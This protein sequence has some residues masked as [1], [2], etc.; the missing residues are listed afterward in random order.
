M[1]YTI[2]AQMS[3]NASIDYHI[4]GLYKDKKLNHLDK[5]LSSSIKATIKK[6]IENNE[7]SGDI[8]DY[9]IYDNIDQNLKVIVFGLGNK[10]KLSPIILNKIIISVLK[11]ISKTNAKNIS[12]NIKNI[13][14]KN[15][16]DTAI[17]EVIIASESSEYKFSIKKV[18]SK[19]SLKKC[20]LIANSKVTKNNFNQ[21][22]T[23]SKAISNGI[24]KA[25]DL[26]N[27]PP[28]ICTPTYLSNEA[29]KLKKINKSLKIT[30]LDEAKIKLLIDLK[31][32][33]VNLIAIEIDRNNNNVT[34]YKDSTGRYKKHKY[35]TRFTMDYASASYT[36][37][38]YYGASA[39]GVFVFSDILGDHRASVGIELQKDIRD[40][41]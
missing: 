21:I 27:T 20:I 39:M 30:I 23:M 24:K 34:I 2:A 15:L 3:T 12:V 31:N 14:S 33:E 6:S 26:G 28:N 18:E 41:W 22:V 35:L 5:E 32:L 29:L 11:K 10:D 8:G 40:R 17:K 9:R 16:I 36:Y 13:Y 1:D 4:I 19:S 37:D 7:I 38:S 25:K